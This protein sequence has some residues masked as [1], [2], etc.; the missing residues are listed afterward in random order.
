M[1][2]ITFHVSTVALPLYLPGRFTHSVLSIDDKHAQ[3]V[4]FSRMLIDRSPT[5]TV[6]EHYL[7]T[8]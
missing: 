6:V 1:T 7:K 4:L 3:N 5:E 8:L 2:G